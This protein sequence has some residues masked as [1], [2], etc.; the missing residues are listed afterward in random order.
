[1]GHQ[2][3]AVELGERRYDIHIEAG[4]TPHAGSLIAPH[5]KGGRVLV[6]AD[7]TVARLHGDTFMNGLA[8]AGI[9]ATMA[10]FP[11]GEP[12]KSLS[13]CDT[14]WQACA[15]AGI[16]RSGAIIALGGGVSGDM[17]GFV[18]ATWMRGIDFIQ[19]PTTL[20]SMVDSSVGGKTGINSAAGKNLI[21]A[22]K[23]PRFVFIDPHH[24]NTMDDREY[25]AGL[26]EVIK[27][28]IIYD[29]E[30][31][32]WQENNTQ[33]LLDRDHEAVTYAVAKSCAI[34]AHYVINDEQ[35]HGIRGHLNYGHT[36]GHALE[37]HT[38]YQQYLHGEAVA[39]GMNMAAHC[40]HRCGLLEDELLLSRQAALI[41]ALKLPGHHQSTAD[42][43][44]EAEILTG[45]C[46]LDKKVRKG[47]TRFIVPRQFGQ[48]EYLEAPSATDVTASF[49]AY[50][51][52]Q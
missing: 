4:A 24:L 14:L 52:N 31:F 45:Y 21:G 39:I 28:G 20:L 27:Y 36:F 25:R 40:A 30:F 34:K 7:A 1:M 11:A 33:A 13:T 23:Q 10:T 16:D 49:A 38:Q 12:H 2:L 22:F 43:S 19:C 6:I 3:V 15:E 35:E 18:A 29:P 50:I 41:T 44:T 8:A 5:L 42:I 47:K 46:K 51:T 9:Q 26:A 37:R 17:A 48:I 32:T